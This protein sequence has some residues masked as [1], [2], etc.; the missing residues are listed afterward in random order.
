MKTNVN[1]AVW[2]VQIIMG[3]LFLI[4]SF[5]KLTSHP[6]AV[7][8][9]ENWGYPFGFYKVIGIIEL[10]CGALLFYPK[11]AGYATIMLIA[12]MSGAVVTH[13]VHEEWLIL[14]KPI[15]HA[16]GLLVIFHF[17]FVIQSKI[18]DAKYYPLNNAK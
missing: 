16:I 18:E 6:V 5:W 9:F 10:V 14:L 3:V 11:A 2:V 8:N 7:E 17:R 4:E 13:I 15:S 12:V 1:R